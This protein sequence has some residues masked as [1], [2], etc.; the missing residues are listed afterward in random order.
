MESFDI[1]FIISLS[2]GVTCDLRRID[3][4]VMVRTWGC[5]TERSGVSPSTGTDG[6]VG[7]SAQPSI[8]AFVVR[9][10]KTRC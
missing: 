2:C 6:V 3:A 7:V 10:A 9:L 1:F 4:H 5:I 8:L